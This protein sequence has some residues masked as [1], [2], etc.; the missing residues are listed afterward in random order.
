[1][2]RSGQQF[3]DDRPDIATAYEPQPSTEE[4]HP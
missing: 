4:E 1:M 3:N 2:S